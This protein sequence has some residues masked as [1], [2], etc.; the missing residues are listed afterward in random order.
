M[1][2]SHLLLVS[3]FNQLAP[4]RKILCALPTVS[5]S[6]LAALT[7]S[8][9]NGLFLCQSAC[10]KYGCV[11]CKYGCVAGVP[12][13]K[14]R[15]SGGDM[16]CIELTNVCHTGILDRIR[17]HPLILQEGY[18]IGEIR[19]L[20]FD[21]NFF[22][23]KQFSRLEILELTSG[24]LQI[25]LDTSALPS[26]LRTLSIVSTTSGDVLDNYILSLNHLENLES[27][28]LECWAIG[29]TAIKHINLPTTLRKLHISDTALHLCKFKLSHVPAQLTDLQLSNTGLDEML[30]MSSLP[31][32]LTLV[33]LSR[34]VLTG[35][36]IRMHSQEWMQR[37]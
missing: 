19:L 30:S 24:R 2:V 12:K 17:L 15:R 16:T 6:W 31:R 1:A 36:L 27:L 28:E 25:P 8:S 34:N 35:S 5:K 14:K 13:V 11:T 26:S 10:C 32:S 33:N 4:E 21:L 37:E 23:P 18:K 29:P 3:A 22:N 20:K 9:C 7:D